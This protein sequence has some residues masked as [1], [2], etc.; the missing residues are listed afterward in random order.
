M[1]TRNSTSALSRY[2]AERRGFLHTATAITTGTLLTPHLSWSTPSRKNE[3]DLATELTNQSAA[4]DTLDSAFGEWHRKQSA[5]VG[6]GGTAALPPS[7]ESRRRDDKISRAARLASLAR[8]DVYAYLNSRPGTDWNTCGQ[9]AMA[10]MLDF[11]HHDPYSLPR[12]NIGADRRRHWDHGEIIDA[13]ISAGFGPD[14]VFGWGT[15]G[16]RLAGGLATNGLPAEVGY[17]GL[18]SSGWPELWR[19]L[20]NYVGV[21]RP[22]PVLVDV[23]ALGGS[24]YYAHW[25]IAYRI[26]A[27]TVY[28]AACPWMDGAI[29]QDTF[30][31]AWGCWFLPYNLNHCSVWV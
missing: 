26:E 12:P 17:S 9:A 4:Q 23:G 27:G 5:V 10:T 3:A 29:P 18:F 28:L 22:V 21:G 24:Y 16:F 25:A 20:Q 14:V 8:D 7:V 2:Q 31:R 1:S 30:L 11:Y 19:A 15:T 13:L 6:A